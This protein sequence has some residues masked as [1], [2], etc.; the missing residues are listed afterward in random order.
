MEINVEEKSGRSKMIWTEK[1]ENDMKIA[2]LI[3]G[4]VEDIAEEMND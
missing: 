1:I 3:K 4:E 2:W